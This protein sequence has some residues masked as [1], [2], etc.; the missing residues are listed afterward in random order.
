MRIAG[1][2]MIV[3]LCSLPASAQDA[4]F[5]DGFEL[6]HPCRWSAQ[7]AA[8]DC[9]AAE[10]TV[11]LPG[12]VPL[13]LVRIPAGSFWMGSPTSERARSGNEDLHQVTLTQDFYLGK[14]EVTQ[15]QWQALIGDTPWWNCGNYGV[16]AAYPVYCVSWWDATSAGGFIGQLNSSLGTTAFRL[17]TD[18]EWEWAARAG[19][20]TRFSHGDVLECGDSC[21]ACAFHA[22]FMWW[23]GYLN[24]SAQPVGSKLP[25]G[26]GLYD[27]HGNV[28]ELVQD[29]WTSHLGT[30]PVVDPTGPPWSS[31]KV[32]RGG[33]WGDYAHHARSAYRWAANL[34]E[35]NMSIGFRVAMTAP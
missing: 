11:L 20:Q 27:V 9:S 15:E 5:A 23:C 31:D 22:E 2:V 16:G 28:Y 32:R 13:T 12:G 29:S 35:R 7:E 34:G 4:L 10:V 3:A 26:F 14:Y 1:V 6:S 24:Q 30:D 21:E 17:P 33:A 19:T 18:A 8:A 25:N